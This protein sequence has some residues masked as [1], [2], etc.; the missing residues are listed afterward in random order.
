MTDYQRKERETDWQMHEIAQRRE[1]VLDRKPALA[2]PRHSA[3][4]S[5]PLRCKMR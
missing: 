3:P 2:S 1:M 4:S 5:M